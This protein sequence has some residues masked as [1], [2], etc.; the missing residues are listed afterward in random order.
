[1]AK[2]I[3]GITVEIDGDTTKLGKALEEVD[4]KSR[5]LQS[6]LK[7]V[8]SL[9]KFDPSNLVLL[10]QKQQILNDSIDDTKQKL[11]ILK[12]A[13]AEVQ[14]QFDKGDITA[15]QYRDFQREIVV[16]EQKLGG[17]ET[18]L[19]GMDEAGDSIDAVA[20]DVAKVG[21]NSSGASDGLDNVIQRLDAGL[22][23]EAADQLG[24]VADKLVDIGTNAMDAA[25]NLGQAQTDLQA[26]LGLTDE[27]TAALGE[28]V[29]NVFQNGVVGSM[30]EAASAVGG[31]KSA[32]GDLNDA[33]LEN[34]TNQIIG[35]STRT[36]TDVTEN[37][38]AA[39]RIMNEFG[40]S[41]EDAM[42]LIAAGY[43]NNLN[44]SDDFTD[45]V[46]EYSTH[47]ANA[48][49]SAD[50]M[51][52]IL[53]NGME[54][55]SLNTDKAADAVKELQIRMGDGSFEKIIGSF[56]GETQGMFDKWKNGEATVSDVA[57]SIS[58]D[59][60]KMTPTEQQA[61]LSLL[62]SQ[63]EDLGVDGAAALFNVGDAFVDVGG[64][65]DTFTEKSPGEEWQSS[66]RGLQEALLPIGE[67]LVAGL[68]PV[69]DA[70]S[71][72][73][74]WFSDLPDPIINFI[75]IFGGLI[76]AVGILAPIIATLA[77]AFTLL[78][79]PLLPIIG[80]IA[81][82]ALAIT[83]AIYVFQNWGAITDWIS[84]KWTA[85]STWVGGLWDSV[86]AYLSGAFDSAKIYLAGLWDSIQSTMSGFITNV[87]SD[88]DGIGSYFSGLWD[89]ITSTFSNAWDGITGVVE[90]AKNKVSGFIGD[91]KGF[92]DGLSLK[93][94]S[95]EMPSLPTFTISGEWDLSLLDGDGL[96]APTVGVKWNAEGGVLTKPTIFGAMGNS[97]LGGGEA[98]NEAILPL[99]EDVLGGIG[100][101][102]AETMAGSQS[103]G[104]TVH[105]NITSPTPLTPSETA[106]LT[107]LNL[108][109]MAYN[110]G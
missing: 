11:G 83:A 29:Q 21:D 99:T 92:F 106:R 17:L 101:G 30:D 75:T 109:Q 5:G 22:F 48:G 9:L 35:V 91:I 66:L 32:F 71:K 8:E 103:G 1:M 70:L 34:L 39:Q 25:F 87:K 40:V 2:K 81:G 47:F 95:I 60:S 65:A 63:F 6:E 68:T 14:A 15:Q 36:G 7:G 61:A 19:K 78:N 76:A 51:M 79:I 45:T 67:A 110:F 102:I 37:T 74:Q 59:L 16:T 94:P 58:G 27:E 97:L 69:M 77:V 3:S 31:V 53:K 88:W 46:N 72:F 23:M 89:G 20:D 84:E 42:N 33:D 86:I 13:Q 28:V 4:S 107:R 50:E 55:G 108:Q 90:T 38:R 26:Q 64:K 82:I 96:S 62:S 57:T 98:G 85:F 105:Q 10:E 56:S 100:R 73:G 18:K 49:Y 80:I 104:I 24:A 43:Q 12:D 44:A 52:Q 41:G 93:L 54:N